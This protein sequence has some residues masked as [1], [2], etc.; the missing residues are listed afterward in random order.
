MKTKVVKHDILLICSAFDHI[1]E[2]TRESLGKL[3]ILQ[4]AGMAAAAKPDNH[5]DI[6]RGNITAADITK[7][8]VFSIKGAD[9]AVCHESL[10][11]FSQR[12]I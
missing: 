9:C 6:V 5:F 2:L 12:I 8:V 11:S 4:A 3:L 7:F 1:Q 10:I